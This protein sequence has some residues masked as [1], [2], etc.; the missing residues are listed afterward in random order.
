[1]KTR[2][3]LLISSILVVSNLFAQD[4]F[5]QDFRTRF[6][7]SLN[8]KPIKEI[9]LNWTEEARFKNNS[10]KFDRL[11]SGL[12]ITYN[13]H[14]NFSMGAI[15]E[16][17]VLQK[18]VDHFQFRHRVKFVV[19]PNVSFG[20]FNLSLREM[21]QMTYTDY[22]D[23]TLRSRLKL[24]YSFMNKHLKPYVSV[25]MYNPLQNV[26]KN[27][28]VTKV[29]YRAGLEWKIDSVNGLEFYYMFEHE[30]KNKAGNHIVGVAYNLGL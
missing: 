21:P 7:L 20:R 10:S 2:L 4:V 3:L 17:Q 8:Y 22:V 11:Y 13:A 26:N 23:W 25:E 14:K 15:Y 24:N 18:S 12:G 1:M 6:S 27:N 9:T 16:F 5:M 28:W 19:Q 30:V 29:N